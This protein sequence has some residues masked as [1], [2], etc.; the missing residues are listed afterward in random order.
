MIVARLEPQEQCGFL[1]I[2]FQEKEN[3]KQ[4]SIHLNLAVEVNFPINCF[5]YYY[6]IIPW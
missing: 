6:F 1:S 3:E 5:Y 4:A 2:C